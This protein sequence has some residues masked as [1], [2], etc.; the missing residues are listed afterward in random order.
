MSHR[1]LL[2]ASA[3]AAAAAVF[4]VPITALAAVY[5]DN[6]AGIEVY[7]TSTEGVFSGTAGGPL[8]GLWSA[9]VLHT[10]LGG[11]P[12]QATI[13]GGVFGLGTGLELVTGAFTGGKVVQ[14]GGLTGC[15]N[16][17]YTVN[18][19]LSNVGV[20]GQAHTGTG[21]FLAVLTHYR[22]SVF[23]A[24]VTYGAS[25]KGTVSLSF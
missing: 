5:S 14:T 11:T 17:T 23:G 25:I 20:Y 18:G 16:Q 1:T 9:S 6:V 13:V 10:P 19:T 7:A 3:I 2:L 21:G 24:C 22:Y 15:T 4:A 12:Q 8:P